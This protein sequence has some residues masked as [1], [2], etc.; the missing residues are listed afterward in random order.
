MR[1][2]I[3]AVFAPVHQK[4]KGQIEERIKQFR[5]D[6]ESQARKFSR[7]E[8]IR[9]LHFMS[10]TVFDDEHYDPILVFEANFDGP[11]DAFWRDFER[12]LGQDAREILA[13]CEEPPDPNKPLAEFF[14]KRVVLPSASH[15]GNRGMTVQQILADRA[16]FLAGQELLDGPERTYLCNLGPTDLH[17]A[18]RAK[19]L[20]NDRP[21]MQLETA[22][23]ARIEGL[24]NY[25]AFGLFVGAVLGAFM[26]PGY[27]AAKTIGGSYRTQALAA[28]IAT[29]LTLAGLAAWLRRLE[30]TD[31]V[32]TAPPPLE[33]VQSIATLEN[34]IAQNHLA[35]IV[36]VKPGLLR[37]G[38][39]RVGLKALGLGVRAFSADGYLGNMRT[40]HFAHWSLINNGGRL[41]FLSNYDGSWESYLDDFID[42]AHSGLTLAWSNC[43]G[44]PRTQWL[45][46]GGATRGRLFKAWARHSQQPSLF[47]F[48]AYRD[49][50]VNQIV[51]N[52]AFA[53]AL[54]R[55][56]LTQKE[57]EAWCKLL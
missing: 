50:T 54:R 33:R 27:A 14:E 2:T 49:L 16:L 18:L 43:V 47:W 21:Q 57:M 5:I 42:K 28:A 13:F 22:G 25:G 31:A 55:P 44:F 52:A 38:L 12:T 46:Q 34:K 26:L 41:L 9:T 19:L 48:N 4:S 20:P 10:L 39:I 6:A 23:P 3:L 17:A 7:V 1:Q 8:Q 53:D 24:R 36:L 56:S 29:T 37:A 30:K 35:S 32:Q 40:I 45:V 51:R 15:Q 11:P